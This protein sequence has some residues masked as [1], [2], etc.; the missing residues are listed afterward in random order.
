MMSHGFRANVS[1]RNRAQVPLEI[2]GTAGPAETFALTPSTK[3][4]GRTG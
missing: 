4:T 1:L 2:E 3:R